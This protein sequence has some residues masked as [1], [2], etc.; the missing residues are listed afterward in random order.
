MTAPSSSVPRLSDTI[1]PGM[2]VYAVT[3]SPTGQLAALARSEG[4][5]GLF[6]LQ[7]HRITAAIAPESLAVC[8]AVSAGGGP[9]GQS[10][11]ALLAYGG[12]DGLVRV[13]SL[14]DG[15]ARHRLDHEGTITC[16]AFSRDGSLLA[17]GGSR[18]RLRVWDAQSG[19]RRHALQH[20]D[21]WLTKVTAVA[22]SPDGRW[23][24]SGGTD[25]TVRLWSVSDGR[26][27]RV[28]RPEEKAT[29]LDFSRDGRYLAASSRGGYIYLWDVESGQTLRVLWHGCR[30]SAVAFAPHG[31]LLVSGGKDGM[32]RP[33]DIESGR[34]LLTLDV[35]P[36]EV[37][38]VYTA[39]FVDDGRL[40]AAGRQEKN[41]V[42]RIWT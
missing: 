38:E 12:Q 36:E 40:M 8:L 29:A 10:D 26:Q 31:R 14:S 25:G 41:L 27:V 18:R 28:H 32:L 1:R 22:F 7:S 42:L 37:R 9:P 16:V 33:W 17:S 2:D 5:I 21:G 19:T 3:F 11:P 4:T 13:H 30:T 15:P 39:R 35:G 6:D 34:E 23:L 20:G 24:A